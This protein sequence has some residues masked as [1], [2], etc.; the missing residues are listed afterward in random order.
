MNKVSFTHPNKV[1]ELA[2]GKKQ[3]MNAYG[4][5]QAL[6]DLTFTAIPLAG[7]VF[8]FNGT[9]FTLIAH[10]ATPVGNQIALGTDLTTT[11]DAFVAALNGSADPA[12]AKATYSNVGG[13]KLHVLFD[14]YGAAGNAYTLVE[15]GSTATASGA[16]LTG[17]SDQEFDLDAETKAITTLAGTLTEF[18]LIAGEEGQETTVYLAVKGAG[19]NA[20]LNGTFVGG[21]HLTLDTVGK[22]AKLKWLGAAWQ[23]LWNTG[24]IA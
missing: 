11:I 6:G 21:T 14:A 23:P 4:K 8:T 19:S 24:T 7:E 5:R 12:V 10:G 18:D 16:T 22:G 1:I 9:A 15:A 17:G 13:T 2:A 20:Q 3:S